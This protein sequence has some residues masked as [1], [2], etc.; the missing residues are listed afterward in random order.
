MTTKRIAL[1][2]NGLWL[3]TL[4]F[5]ILSV[6]NQDYDLKHG[7]RL[8]KEWSNPVLFLF[9]SG[10]LAVSVCI[11]TGTC[12]YLCYKII[13]S[14][15]VFKS[16]KR[17]ASEEQK[18]VKVGRLVEVLQ[19][20]VK[21]TFSMFMAGGIDAAFEGLGIIFLIWRRIVAFDSKLSFRNFIVVST[22]FC[23]YLPCCGVCNV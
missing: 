8:L 4:A 6:V 22:Q 12:I 11:I 23:Q 16:V 2:I 17:N 20:Q 13:H 9:I 19:E 5:G 18:A 14:N 7:M 10:S 3:M 21:S 1:T 15:Q